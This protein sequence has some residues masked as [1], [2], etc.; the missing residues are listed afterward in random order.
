MKKIK[1]ILIV[2]DMEIEHI[3]ATHA[4]KEYNEAI[5][6]VSASG[7]EEALSSIKSGKVSP[8]LILLDINMPGMNGFDFLEEFPKL[9]SDSAPII[10]ML[11]S[12]NQVSDQ[13]RAMNYDFVKSFF[14]KPLEPE[15]LEA[16]FEQVE[17]S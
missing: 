13:E 17:M 5:E 7:A 6:V 15:H 8:D 3:V 10:A 14:T 11:S 2:D 16:F 9:T 1:Q 12:S 4:I